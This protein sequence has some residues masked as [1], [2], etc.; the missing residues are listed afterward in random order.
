MTVKCST[1]TSVDTPDH[2]TYILTLMGF[3]VNYFQDKS[4][5]SGVETIVYF[6]TAVNK[7]DSTSYDATG[8]HYLKRSKTIDCG[9]ELPY[10]KFI[11][12]L[13]YGEFL[14]FVR[15]EV[16]RLSE[17]FSTLNIKNFDLQSY[18]KDLKSYLDRRMN[19]IKNKIPPN[20]PEIKKEILDYFV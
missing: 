13:T 6:I 17:L 2:G 16:L 8:T 15:N 20:Y 1:A 12:I 11:K 3:T 4:Y 9:I 14:E 19:E 10:D 18:I 7:E 5:G